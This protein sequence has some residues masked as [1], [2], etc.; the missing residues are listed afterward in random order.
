MIIGFLEQ[1]KGF[2]RQFQHAPHK[3]LISSYTLFILSKVAFHQKY[4][5]V[6]GRIDTT[7]FKG[8]SLPFGPDR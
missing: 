7:E 2:E 5:L 1:I 4:P 8:L 6:N 3:S